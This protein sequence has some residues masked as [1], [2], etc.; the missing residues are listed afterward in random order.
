VDV[1][2]I[3]RRP[4]AEALGDVIATVRPSLEQ[5][6]PYAFLGAIAAWLM[7]AAVFTTAIPAGTD[8]F[9]FVTRARENAVGS[10]WSSVWAPS[11]FGSPRPYTLDN[12]LGLATKLT[13]D[14]LV[15]VKL[16]SVLTLFAS[17]IFAML[18]VRRWFQDRTAAVFAGAL[19]MTSQASLSRWASGQVN[20]EM[21]TAMAPLLLLLWS[22]CHDRFAPRAA[23]AFA[24]AMSVLLLVRLDMV[25]YSAPFLAIYTVV[26]L[27]GEQEHRSCARALAS[28]VAV[29]L[30]AGL[31]LN[32]Y[33]LVPMLA[34]VRPQW[35]SASQLFTFED[36]QNHSLD[37]FHS[38]LGFGREIGYLG[39][40]GQ[41]TWYSHP[42]VSAPL[43]YAAAAVLVLLAA[44]TAVRRWSETNVRFLAIGAVA[45]TFMGKGVR[46]PLGGA[47]AWAVSSIPFFGNLRNPNRWLIFQAI[48][49][50][51]LGGLALARLLSAIGRR[52]RL[53]RVTLRWT[54][55]RFC[56]LLFV[57]MLPVAP[58]LFSGFQTWRPSPDQ[59][60]LLQTVGAGATSVVATVPFDQSVRY[61]R[62][63]A[64]QGYEH[65]LG[66]ES[67]TFTGR[68][69][70]SDGGWSQS[71]ADLIA[72][73]STL[74]QNHDPAFQE[75]LGS[76]GVG[77]LLRFSYPATAP[78]LLRPTLGADWQQQAIDAIPGFVPTVS[79]PSGSVYRLRDAAPLVSLR[80][81]VAVVLGGASGIAA[82]ADTPGV[83]LRD[84]AAMTVQDLAAKG[85]TR[86]VVNAIRSADL[87][88][89]SNESVPDVAVGITPTLA[90]IEGI[91]S[92]TPLDRLTQLIG[93]D[94]SIRSGSMADPKAPMPAQT[95]GVTSTITLHAPT[96][97]ELWSRI[98][99][100]PDAAGLT[101]RV[102]GRDVGAVLP[103][104]ASEAGFRWVRVATVRLGSGP[105][106]VS[107]AAA[108]SRYGD[109]FEIDQSRLLRPAARIRV[110]SA[111]L[112]S[113]DARRGHIEYAFDLAD[114]AKWSAAPSSNPSRPVLP[115]LN[116]WAPL[117]G[118][119]TVEPAT[120][121]GPGTVSVVANAAR[122]FY[123]VLD[124][125]LAHAVDLSGA[126]Y[127]YLPFEG[128]A[129][130]LRYDF[131]VEFAGGGEAHFLF[132]D[133]TT[134]AR[135]I[136]FST[137]LPDR[138]DEPMDWAHVRGFRL[139]IDTPGH[140][141]RFTVGIPRAS[142]ATGLSV[143]LP[144][145]ASQQRR[146]V[147]IRPVGEPGAA[148]SSSSLP[149]GARTV[150]LRIPVSPASSP[151]RVLVPPILP[152]RPSPPAPVTLRSDGPTTFRY[153]VEVPQGGMLV[154]AQASQPQWQAHDRVDGTIA[155]TPIG[156]LDAGFRLSPGH[157]VGTIS[158][159][160]QR[161]ADSGLR[162]SLLM[163]LGLI[164]ASIVGWRRRHGRPGDG[165]DPRRML[166]STAVLGLVVIALLLGIR[167]L[168]GV[169][170]VAVAA[171]PPQPLA[172]AP[173]SWRSVEPVHVRVQQAA[174][175]TRVSFS[176]SRSLYT[177]A[178][179]RFAAPQ[180]WVGRRWLFVQ[181]HG[182][183]DGSSYR[184]IVD[185]D[186]GSGGS[187]SFIVTDVNPGWRVVALDL[188]HP[189]QV[190]GTV[191]WGRVSAL[192]IARDGR[193][194]S[195]SLT[196]GDISLTL[197]HT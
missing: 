52:R 64:Y 141:S 76:A 62:Q 30:S 81:N 140:G 184:V 84:W 158:F 48:A 61:L 161:A 54:L 24:V 71:S 116:A 29:A 193:R 19:Y 91:T 156:S 192:R 17:G 134:N 65:D 196:I 57:V 145:L 1:P 127:V 8:M 14:P 154:F 128:G 75:V 55:P 114:A 170:D 90:T 34:G 69:T 93:S 147:T 41:Q 88:V 53:W 89:M 155:P 82:L 103:L 50:A 95:S 172:E 148:V 107:I 160:G 164:A 96:T 36:L 28:N 6:G 112:R 3:K 135:V 70:L 142:T 35:A 187:A 16:L 100:A 92:V 189:D 109:A 125:S 121:L 63:G 32:A 56:V 23:I 159:T 178:T 49:Y 2:L 151:A 40:T 87:V 43:Y 73:A 111:L 12:V 183:G 5:V 123:T 7:R 15:T 74:L 46:P 10:V 4:L 152:L 194:G 180:D 124:S 31:A 44:A 173:R 58:T 22:R 85:G 188:W 94:A 162:I 177:L 104:T 20:V 105:H 144:V 175:D 157:H 108:P 176:G 86:A 51:A 119:G 78:H 21:A 195:G 60:E 174:G 98:R 139:A 169:A 126:P 102:D 39:F 166:G 181:L 120:G 106:Q 136:P 13:G 149:A 191:D 33:Q 122:R 26:R 129:S 80:T 197:P 118:S 185:F 68:P 27:V 110:E 138:G 66:A 9:G 45:A 42:Y 130:G 11:V 97:V 79:D 150:A 165:W 146:L 143:H 67:T 133:D 113:L 72:Y 132:T 47:Y 117:G 168:P 59:V 25:L 167:A 99:Y 83:D 171:V 77:Q 37:L 115:R 186:A 137:A 101:F 153:S 179:H 163:F 182:Q 131:V 38:A 18:L 190:E